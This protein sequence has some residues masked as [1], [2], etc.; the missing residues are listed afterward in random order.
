MKN[1]IIV[2]VLCSMSY[3]LNAPYLISATATSDG[4]VSLAW[5]NNDVATT[6]YIVQRKDSTEATYKFMDSVQ[7]VTTLAYADSKRLLPTTLYTY[8]VIA[9]S[10]T[11]V[12]DTSNSAQVTTAAN[13][14]IAPN[15][16]SATALSR[17][18]LSLSWQDND[19]MTWG[20]FIR[21][22]DSTE[23]A[24]HFVDSIKSAT[25][26]AYKDTTGLK[27]GTF[28]TYQVVAYYGGND[29][30]DTSNS[31]QAA[32]MPDTFRKPYPSVVWDYTNSISAQVAFFDYSNCEIGYRIYRDDGV[33]SAFSLV[34]TIISANPDTTGGIAWNDN[35]VSLNKWYN[36]KVAVYNS[37]SSILSDSVPAYTFHSVQM[38]TAVAFQKLSTF[39]VSLS[40]WSAKAGDSII[41]KENSS[42]AAKYSVVN[43]KD[44]VNPKFVG[45]IDSAALLSYPLQTLI[46]AFLK[47][48][49]YNSVSRT[50]AI[51]CTNKMLVSSGNG[52]TM[53]LIQNGNLVS[54]DSI[55]LS[56][57][58]TMQQMLLLNDSLLAITAD[59]S[60]SSSRT[61]WLDGFLVDFRHKR[62]SL[63]CPTGKFRFFIFP[64]L[65]D[66]D[67]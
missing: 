53:Y 62:Q 61:V 26:L 5:R 8:Q 64:K 56:S 66:S 35:T 33:N 28:Y 27:P 42:P 20:F 11:A 49:V 44:P 16:A 36:Y 55:E 45:Y 19:K 2:L 54:V 21:R 1:L 65:S 15:L 6:G 18:S 12:S 60:Y 34:A 59:S 14:R 48:G 63:F 17:H 29:E 31:M 40:G 25:V 32:T 37:D 51:Q 22:K 58:M 50:R 30:Y 67:K 10:A 7:S 43:V 24:F 47:F 23:T 13:P 38:N 9:Y 46:P 39:P 57:W 4:S 3:A 52:V 41:F